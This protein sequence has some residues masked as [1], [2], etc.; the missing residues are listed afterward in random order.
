MCHRCCLGE[1]PFTLV[2]AVPWRAD[3]GTVESLWGCL[4]HVPHGSLSL[5]SARLRD[6]HRL[7]LY[8][9]GESTY[10]QVAGGQGH[11][12]TQTHAHTLEA[13]KYTPRYLWTG[14][15]SLGCVRI[16]GN[17]KDKQI[18]HF[19]Q[20]EQSI[21]AVFPLFYAP[22]RSSVIWVY[23]TTIVLSLMTGRRGHAHLPAQRSREKK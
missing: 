3:M 4:V 2:T 19:Q 6:T 10:C 14:R 18:D 1:E 7:P 20:T 12:N 9:P 13:T 15:L 16:T 8:G 22:P 5:S 17:L 21:K 23:R 11:T